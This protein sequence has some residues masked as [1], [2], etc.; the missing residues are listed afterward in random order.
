MKF[1][2]SLLIGALTGACAVL[3]HN[4]APPFGPILSFLGTLLAIWALGRKFGKRSYKFFAAVAWLYVFSKASMLGSGG[5]LLVQGDN[6]GS[7]LAF[8]GITALIVAIALPA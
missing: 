5:E 8:F 2:A 1:A 7:S 6:A 3:I 4:F